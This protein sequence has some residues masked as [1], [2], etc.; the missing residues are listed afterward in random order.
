MTNKGET[1]L[2]MGFEVDH[3]LACMFKGVWMRSVPY[4]ERSGI[5]YNGR[6]NMLKICKYRVCRKINKGEIFKGAIFGITMEY[7]SEQKF[8]G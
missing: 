4:F 2:N 5:L 8:L 6:L 3:P 1:L 7:G